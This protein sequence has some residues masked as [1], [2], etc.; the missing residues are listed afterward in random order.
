MSMDTKRPTPA[1]LLTRVHK[2]PPDQR[3]YLLRQI[4]ILKA[5]ANL[6][7]GAALEVLYMLGTYLNRHPDLE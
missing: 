2:L 1:E 7:T 6:G 3:Q 5:N 4:G